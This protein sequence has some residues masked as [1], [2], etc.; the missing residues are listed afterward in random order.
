M[1]GG[2]NV[3]ADLAPLVPTVST[4]AVVAADPEAILTASE[5][6]GVAAWKRDPDASAFAFWRRQPRMVA[7]RKPQSVRRLEPVSALSLVRS[8]VAA[9]V[10][11]SVRVSVVVA[12]LPCRS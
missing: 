1:C 8:P 12:Q 4:E 9:K 6:G 11:L 3:F 2:R 7:V 5:Q 10:R